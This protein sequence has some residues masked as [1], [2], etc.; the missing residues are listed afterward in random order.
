MIEADNLT[1]R[2]GETLAVDSVSFSIGSGEIVGLLGHNGAGK[3]TIMRILTGYLEPSAGGA[4]IDGRDVTEQ[5]AA[6]QADVGYLPENVPLYQDMT[7]L[8]YLEFAATARGVPAA[9]RPS[10]CGTTGISTPRWREPATGPSR[11]GGWSPAPPWASAS[12]CRRGR[13]R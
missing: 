2:F 12:S 7:V 4:R 11:P 9:R 10:T 8:D 1:R 13:R 5:R 3:T 6:V